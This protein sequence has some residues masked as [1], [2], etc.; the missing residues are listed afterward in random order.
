MSETS[1]IPVVRKQL[2]FPFIAITSLFFLWGI[3]NDLTNPMVS[4]FKKVMP[5]LSNF[6][7]AL[8]QLA[9]YG[10]YA[11]MA[12]PAALFIRKYSYKKGILLGL[13]LYATGAFLFYPAAAYEEF[14]FFLASLY[15]LTFG[16]AF[17]ETTSNPFILSMGDA[18]TATRRLNLSQAFNPMGSLLGMLVAQLF[19]IQS[20]KSDD[21]SAEAYAALSVAEKAGIRENDLNIISFPYIA[22]GILVVIILLVIALTKFPLFRE[23]SKMSLKTSFSKLIRNRRYYEGVLAQAFYV[24]AQIMCWTFIFQYVDHLNDSRGPDEQLTATWYN[25]AAMALFLSGRWLCTWLLKYIKGPRLML[26]F[27]LAGILF[28]AGTILLPGT[29]GLYSLVAISACMSLM[30]PTIYGIALK[31]MGDEAKLG[32][33]G[34]VM[35]IV[36]GALM[37]PLQ[38]AILDWG[39]PGFSEV[40]VAGSIP[41]VKFS[42]ILPLL[43]LA[44]VAI[45]SFRSLNV[46]D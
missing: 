39:G 45:Y 30:F 11:T 7:A 24:G 18:E 4:A 1:H 14:G 32:S 35:A 38:A 9:F 43:C 17:L 13:V 5:E 36:G 15:I 44:V 33:A 34:L 12:I 6:E 20:L 16:L 28:A 22:L 40:M 37:P 19:V 41:E 42:F 31:G 27:A 46:S 3:A 8:V 26:F 2:L 23:E 10:G 25:M 29:A 21:Y